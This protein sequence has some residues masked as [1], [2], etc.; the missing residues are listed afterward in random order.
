M[1][2]AGIA[3]E[4][5]NE[6][7]KILSAL[8]KGD[9]QKAKNMLF[10]HLHNLDSEKKIVQK[11]FPAYFSSPKAQNRFDVD[12]GGLNLISGAAQAGM[13]GNEKKNKK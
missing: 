4:K 6:H 11:E 13:A 9:P 7:K 10:L 8:K 2:M 3:D 12:F 5:I 1:W